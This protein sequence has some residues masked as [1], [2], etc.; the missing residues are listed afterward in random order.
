MFKNIQIRIKTPNIIINFQLPP[1]DVILSTQRCPKV[2]LEL[3]DFLLILAGSV[4]LFWRVLSGLVLNYF[5]HLLHSINTGAMYFWRYWFNSEIEMIVFKLIFGNSLRIISNI[6]FLMLLLST[7]SDSW[8][9][10]FDIELIN[11]FM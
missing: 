7:Y 9:S 3:Y 2:N 10:L 8:Y 1:K 5:T 4:S 11:I 6:Y